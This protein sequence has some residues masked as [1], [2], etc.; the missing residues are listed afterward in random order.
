VPVYVAYFK[1]GSL[2]AMSSDK[3]DTDTSIN[4]FENNDLIAAPLKW[5]RRD[6]DDI[7]VAD[8]ATNNEIKIASRDRW[9]AIPVQTGL[10]SGETVKPDVKGGF[11]DPC[12]YW[13]G[14]GDGDGTNN[15][16]EDWRLPTTV[17][18]NWFVGGPDRDNW[19][20]AGTT[21]WQDW[22]PG[23]VSYKYYN[24]DER[25]DSSG[26][27]DYFDHGRPSTFSGTVENPSMGSFPVEYQ[28]AT[29][30][31]PERRAFSDHLP[32]VGY[33]YQGRVQHQGQQGNYWSSTANIRSGIDTGYS[34]NFDQLLVTPSL[35]IPLTHPDS[36]LGR[37]SAVRCVKQAPT[38][39]PLPLLPA[40]IK[41]PK[42]VIGYFA[43]GSGLTLAGDPSLTDG[44]YGEG[45]VP[46][47]VAYFKFGSLVAVSSDKSDNTSPYF[48]REDILAAPEQWK[49]DLE[50]TRDYINADWTKI[51]ASQSLTAGNP[52]GADPA[53]GLGDPCDYWFGDGDGY[54][55][56]NA[57]GVWRLPTN[58]ENQTFIG[59][60]A[61][62]STYRSS[63]STYYRWTAGTGGAPGIGT[64]PS[65]SQGNNILPAAGY[66]SATDGQVSS[67]GDDGRYWSSTAKDGSNGYGLYFYRL[68]VYPSGSGNYANTNGY[69]VRCVKQAPMPK[70]VK[71]PKDVIGYYADGPN[72][73]K[74]TL[75]GDATM[76]GDAPS[77]V[78]VYVAYFK[79]GSLVATSSDQTDIDP[80]D[81]A[82]G[83]GKTNYFE[84]ED[85]IA[86]PSTWNRTT[87]NSTTNAA[88]RWE[89]IP[90]SEVPAEVLVVT[91]TPDV[92]KGL[93][94]PCDYWFNN[95]V[96]G[97]GDGDGANNATGEWRLPTVFD[98]IDFVGGPVD[99]TSWGDDITIGKAPFWS[100]W[101]LGNSY[102]WYRD[103][104]SGMTS[105]D[106]GRYNFWNIDYTPSPDN[107]AVGRFPVEKS[108]TYPGI[109]AFSQPL[110]ALGYR[111]NNENIGTPSYTPQRHGG[112]IGQGTEGRYWSSS[113]K[114]GESIGPYNYTGYSLKFNVDSVY[115]SASG[116]HGYGDDHDNGYAVRCV[117]EE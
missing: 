5:N 107:P 35:R 101:N 83:P 9:D 10:S 21:F 90:A 36:D 55:T 112:V 15:S 113:T 69:A 104:L 60:P 97:R 70:G 30:T 45:E 98:N 31:T 13:F 99:A 77:D 4:Y 96:D 6:F 24:S 84:E 91:V 63:G 3:S 75:A 93:G 71:A 100:E 28:P 67:S 25:G 39:D 57:A 12:D 59:N 47:Y 72:R 49:G 20:P 92:G 41:A 43:D 22:R 68:S 16:A 87:F 17:E 37:G 14:D 61:G 95:D 40:G 33:R 58:T 56:N 54:A 117:R 105:P 44:T 62:V 38:P 86:A 51:P 81:V 32:A 27:Y 1:F 82:V 88:S 52:I 11:G 74:L 108:D 34:I 114:G 78:N 29:N 103:N 8:G 80:R 48:E 115:P 85:L 116:T 109:E 76:G 2:I 89:K 73:G 7:K 50:A 53:S 66:R 94:D 65:Y 42:D 64:F 102:Y 18:N 111:Y 23:E 106:Y 26:K 110:Y 19:K 79:F 46:V